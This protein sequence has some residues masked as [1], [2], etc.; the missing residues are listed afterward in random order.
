MHSEIRRSGA[1]QTYDGVLYNELGHQLSNVPEQTASISTTY[2]LPFKI[3]IGTGF[4]FVDQRFSN[5]IETQGVPGYWLQDAFIS[6]EASKNIDLRLNVSNLWD[7]KY[8]DR[9]GGGHAIP[10]PGRTVIATAAFKF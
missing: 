1:R 7:E 9:V 6:W 10:G 8:I 4:F 3:N 5:N 2:E